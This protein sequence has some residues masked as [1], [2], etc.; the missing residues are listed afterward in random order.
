ML[1][2]SSLT[3]KLAKG[4]RW[5]FRLTVFSS[6]SPLSMQQASL[7]VD[8]SLF[9]TLQ[10]F[11][12]SMRLPHQMTLANQPQSLAASLPTPTKSATNC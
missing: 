9:S 8:L 5:K 6:Q 4:H 11:I 12:P 2:D 1:Q 10:N 3:L 7:Q